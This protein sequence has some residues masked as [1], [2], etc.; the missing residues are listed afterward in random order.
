[1]RKKLT[2]MVILIAAGLL[3]AMPANIGAFAKNDNNI[4]QL[5]GFRRS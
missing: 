2:I 5:N 3:I 4:I 1:M